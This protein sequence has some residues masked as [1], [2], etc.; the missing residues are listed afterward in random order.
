MV[1]IVVTVFNEERIIPKLILRIEKVI[2]SLCDD[3]EVIFVD[4]GSHDK[5]TDLITESHKKNNRIKLIQFSRNF[6]QVYAIR[7]GLHQAK[8][9][10]VVLMDGDLQDQPEEIPKLLAK[11]DEGYDLAYA[12]RLRRQDVLYRRVMSRLFVVL[13]RFLVSKHELPRGHEMMFAGVF[14]AM[15]REVVDA[16]NTLPER[17]VYIQGL[18]YWVGF[19]SALVYVEHD[20]RAGGKSHWTFSKLFR[21]AL[22]ALISFSPYPLRKISILGVIIAFISALAGIGY[23]LQRIFF[24]TRVVGF[25]TLVLIILFLGGIQLFLFGVI[26]EYLGRMYIETKRR[27]LYIIKK[28]LL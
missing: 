22:D 25:T 20:A 27:P 9:D 24:E 13:M 23:L 14:R 4:D 2:S 18:I 16:L 7:A 21:Y 26:G 10:I 17:T 12:C 3:Y 19:S 1:S 6:G 11:L 28:K 5:T 8:G 15:R